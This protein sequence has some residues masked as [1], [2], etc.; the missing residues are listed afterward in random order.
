MDNKT[1]AYKIV[2]LFYDND[3]HNFITADQYP[4]ILKHLL[5][6][7]FSIKQFRDLYLFMHNN[8][9]Q[10]TGIN[11]PAGTQNKY[12]PAILFFDFD[13]TLQL[14][15][16]VHTSYFDLQFYFGNVERQNVLS[17]LLYIA[18]KFNRVYIITNNSATGHI[19][20]LLN[21]LVEKYNSMGIAQSKFIPNEN[22]ICSLGIDKLFLID[23]ISK[24][25]FV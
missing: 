5:Q 8:I 3:V 16:Y 15:E 10:G 7:P 23:Y 25:Q 11:E 24:H 19:A 21:K 18:S 12:K 2:P 17:K 13:G 6:D 22:V 20:I 4:S 14:N 9:L 1:F